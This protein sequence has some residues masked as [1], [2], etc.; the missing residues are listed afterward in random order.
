MQ[1]PRAV[2]DFLSRLGVSGREVQNSRLVEERFRDPDPALAARVVNTL[3]STYITQSLDTRGASAVQETSTWFDE[4]LNEQRKQVA[5]AEAA[6]QNYRER[7]DALTIEGAQNIVV[8]KLGDLNAA[9]T[10]AKT[11]RMQR[12]AIYRQVAQAS[13]DPR[14]L[15]ALPAV[16]SNAFVQQQRAE[17]STLQREQ[18]RVGR[19]AGRPASGHAAGAPGDPDG[20]GRLRARPCRRSCSRCATTTKPPSSRNPA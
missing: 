7:N 18:A 9:V 6:L 4:Q 17:L 12:E 11:E 3:A 20:A 2:S 15:D 14:A 10:R 13:N 16:V 1:T 8:Q 5:D 19:E